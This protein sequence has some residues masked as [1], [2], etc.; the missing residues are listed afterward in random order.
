MRFH[1]NDKSFHDNDTIITHGQ[2][3]I[4]HRNTGKHRTTGSSSSTGKRGEDKGERSSVM[5]QK[6]KAIQKAKVTMTCQA[7]ATKDAIHDKIKRK[8][9]IGT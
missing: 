3:S 8:V 5:L 7:K 6:G 4:K 9:V 1:D 2:V